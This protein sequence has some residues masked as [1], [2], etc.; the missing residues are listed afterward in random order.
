MRS[1]RPIIGLFLLALVPF[2]PLV[3]HPTH[4]PYSVSSDLLAQHLPAKLFLVRSLNETGELPLWNPEQYAGS[5]FVHD[6]QVGLFYPPHLPLYFISESAI[7]PF[8]SWLLFAHVLLAGWLMYAY[9]RHAGLTELAA[10]VAGV[11][12]MLSPRWMMQIFLAGHV[13]TQGICWLPLILLCIERAIVRKKWSWAIAGGMAYAM[14]ILGTHP[15]WTFYAS[16][17]IGFWPLRLLVR[18]RAPTPA[19]VETQKQ[20][21]G[22]QSTLPPSPPASGGEGRGQGG[23]RSPNQMPSSSPVEPQPPSPQPSPPE[24]GG[25]GV[26][27]RLLRWL[28]VEAIVVA[29]GLALCA[30]QLLPTIEAAGESSRARGMAQSWSLDGAKAAA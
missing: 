18:E 22:D 16:L 15:Q 30:V 7:G 8:I 14:L 9:A 12:F 10:F 6:I 27:R 23:V 5:P 11:G 4:T 13:I 28:A 1:Q 29:I 17:L 3:L 21:Y 20:D 26:G 19:L 24:A 25:E 2:W